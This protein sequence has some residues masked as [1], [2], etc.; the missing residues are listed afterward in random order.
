M[1]TMFKLTGFIPVIVGL[2]AGYLVVGALGA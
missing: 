1:E 2:Y